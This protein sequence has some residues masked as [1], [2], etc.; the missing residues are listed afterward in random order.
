MIGSRLMGRAILKIVKTVYRLRSKQLNDEIYSSTT[1][2]PLRFTSDR[3]VAKVVAWGGRRGW[4][5]GLK[6][7]KPYTE[8]LLY[9]T[10]TL[11]SCV[12]IYGCRSLIRRIRTSLSPHVCCPSIDPILRH[13]GC[14]RLE[15]T[16]ARLL[17]SLYLIF[18]IIYSSDQVELAK[19]IER[20]RLYSYFLFDIKE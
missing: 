7:L 4:R 3:G 20:E 13:N 15:T 16:R 5:R 14:L 18:A 9:R 12:V 10:F 2:L 19:R 17:I 1:R 8:G 11:Q 6:G